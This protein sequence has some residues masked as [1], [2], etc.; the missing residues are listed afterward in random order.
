MATYAYLETALNAEGTAE[1]QEKNQELL[2]FSLKTIDQLV[3]E[4]HEF[5]SENLGQFLVHEDLEETYENV[6]NPTGDVVIESISMFSHV[7]SL[8][9]ETDAE[10]KDLIECG[11]LAIG[12]ELDPM[13]V[14]TEGFELVVKNSGFVLVN[15]AND[16]ISS[17]N[18]ASI[19]PSTIAAP[20]TKVMDIT[21]STLDSVI[22]TLDG[23]SASAFENV[24][25]TYTALSGDIVKLLS[26]SN[27]TL[28]QSFV[29]LNGHWGDYLKSLPDSTPAWVVNAANDF[30]NTIKDNIGSGSS[31]TAVVSIAIGAAALGLLAVL[32]LAISLWTG[33]A[34]KAAVSILAAFS[35]VFNKI[36]SIFKKK[37]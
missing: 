35:K 31:D 21:G 15:K 9:E 22:K 28:N 3:R 1:L 26:S 27:A 20:I 14:L 6:Q 17:G 10:K 18:L 29:S 5:T 8:T 25:K 4:E 11:A 36:K 19:T 23:A 24:S 30:L 7:I 16:A 37:K 13:L 32:V 2:D 12:L 33:G 34:K